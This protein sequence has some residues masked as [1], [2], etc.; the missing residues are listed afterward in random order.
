MCRETLQ[1]CLRLD[2]GIVWARLTRTQPGDTEQGLTWRGEIFR[3]MKHIWRYSL[4]QAYFEL[5]R[6]TLAFGQVIYGLRQI[7]FLAKALSMGHNSFVALSCDAP[8]SKQ[9][10]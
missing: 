3:Q 8:E 2:T 9:K 4:L 5:Q 7:L 6:W 1:A 10:L